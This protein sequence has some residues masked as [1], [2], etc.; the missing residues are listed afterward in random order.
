MACRP[1]VACRSLVAGPSGCARGTIG[2]RAAGSD[3]LVVGPARRIRRVTSGGAVA[4]A[5]GP[6]PLDRARRAA[7]AGRLRRRR[8]RPARLR[9]ASSDGA[10]N[11]ARSSAFAA[12]VALRARGARRGFSASPALAPAAASPP[13]S[14]STRWPAGS[15]SPGPPSWPGRPA[16]PRAHRRWRRALRA[17]WPRGPSVRAAFRSFTTSFGVVPQQWM[18]A[19][20]RT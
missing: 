8:R 1:L 6:S 20:A 5:A 17:L 18:G 3:P 4:I 11:S 15:A 13:A 2:R 12:V 9:S 10:P 7:G 16:W 14:A 19:S